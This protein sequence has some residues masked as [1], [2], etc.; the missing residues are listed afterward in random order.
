MCLLK[1]PLK[2]FQRCLLK[3]PSLWQRREPKGRSTL[4]SIDIMANSIRTERFLKRG[5]SR[6]LKGNL[7]AFK[8]PSQGLDEEQGKSK[9]MSETS[10][11]GPLK[12]FKGAPQGLYRDLSRA[13][14]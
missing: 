11:G 13:L 4:I 5:L 14:I 12:A 10:Q 6:P 9:N 3:V 8:V 2:V 7:R 1:V